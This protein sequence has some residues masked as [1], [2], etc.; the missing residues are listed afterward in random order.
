MVDINTSSSALQAQLQASKQPSRL[1][2]RSSFA[3][4]AANSTPSPKDVV[5]ERVEARQDIST[6]DR[7]APVKQSSSTNNLS[8]PSEIED[9]SRRAG[10]FTSGREAPAGRIS[11][12]PENQRPQPLGQIINILV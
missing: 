5:S 6:P 3:D 8:T 11:N 12:A 2:A 9:A 7:R 10:Q 1:S 4:S